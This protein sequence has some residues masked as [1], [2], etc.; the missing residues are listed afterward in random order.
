MNFEQ[1]R[2]SQKNKTRHGRIEQVSAYVD[3]KYADADLEMNNVL[4]DCLATSDRQE[5]TFFKQTRNSIEK[6]L[7]DNPELQELIW[8]NHNRAKVKTSE[9][10]HRPAILKHKNLCNSR[11]SPS[12]ERNLFEENRKSQGLP[13]IQHN[14]VRFGVKSQGGPRKVTNA[15]NKS[16]YQFSDNMT[17][18][19]NVI[20][21]QPRPKQQ[22]INEH[23]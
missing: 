16:D 22:S 19:Q 3:N 4:A 18:I 7:S 20:Q 5:G 13:N 2:E 11:N 8:A 1:I 9:Q 6:N 17:A 12:E 23:L 14:Q 21:K 10:K 15:P